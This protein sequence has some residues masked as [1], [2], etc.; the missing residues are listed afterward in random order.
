M[1]S[2]AARGGKADTKLPDITSVRREWEKYF[3]PESGQTQTLP[4][5]C[6][7]LPRMPPLGSLYSPDGSSAPVDD[8]AL[9]GRFC[10]RLVFFLAWRWLL[11]SGCASGPKRASACVCTCV[12]V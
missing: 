7:P 9:K 11:R 8:S 10:C 3:P 6:R 1:L 2:S 4:A 12:G 5:H